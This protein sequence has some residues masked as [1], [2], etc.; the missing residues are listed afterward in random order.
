[1]NSKLRSLLL[2][3]SAIAMI[4]IISFLGVKTQALGNINDNIISPIISE[5][6]D[7]SKFAIQL[8]CVILALIVS[9]LS[10]ITNLLS[11]LFRFTGGLMYG[12]FINNP[13]DTELAYIRPLWSFL[14]DF[15]NLVVIGSFIA[16]ALVILFDLDLPVSKSLGN[17]AGGIVMVALLLN[18]SLT[19]TSAF[20]STI[21]SIGIGTVYATQSTAGTN[22]D[23]TSRSAFN[24]SV[25]KT[26]NKFFE[27]VN[28]N[29]VNKVSCMGSEA[30]DYKTDKDGRGGSLSMATV[31][32][33]HKLNQQTGPLT[34]WS[35]IA[36]SAEGTPEALIFYMIALIREVIVLILLVAGIYV[37][38]TLLKVSL[39]RLAYLWI[40]GIFAGPALVAAFSPFDGMKNYFKTWLKWL[41]VF[42][43]MMIVFVAGFYLSSY[44]ATISL[45]STGIVFEPLGNPFT[46]PG[47]FITGL[48]NSMVEVVVP[49]IM[50]PIIGLVILFLLGK[51]LDETYQTHAVKAMKAGGKLLSDARNSV[52][53][54]G[55]QVVGLGA[56]A[57][58]NYSN[59]GS[60]AANMYNTGLLK[61]NSALAASQRLRRNEAG[62]KATDMRATKYAGRAAVN[63][64]MI[65]NKNQSID[66]FISGKDYK[67]KRAEVEYLGKMNNSEVLGRLGV[68][69]S[70]FAAEAKKSGLSEDVIN[71]GKSMSKLAKT[72]NAGNGLNRTQQNKQIEKD[73]ARSE[74]KK[75]E[76]DFRDTQARLKTSAE[77]QISNA[78]EMQSQ[79]VKDTEAAYLKESN[80]L[81]DL[82]NKKL[83]DGTF[84][85]GNA[86]YNAKAFEDHKRKVLANENG[87]DRKIKESKEKLSNVKVDIQKMIEKIDEDIS[88]NEVVTT[89]VNQ[90]F[91][92]E[93]P[94]IKEKVADAIYRNDKVT[95]NTKSIAGK[96]Q[97]AVDLQQNIEATA[98][99]L[100]Q[101]LKDIDSDTDPNNT[102]ENKQKRKKQLLETIS[103]SEEHIKRAAERKY[104]AFKANPYLDE[105][106]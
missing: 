72:D 23:L 76:D 25:L 3:L 31:C 58:K 35:L 22:L 14:V 90:K 45:P 100:F 16:L 65:A 64:Q 42:S 87:R 8:V 32:Q 33:F 27:S 77:G 75:F 55:R 39:F 61:A 85:T 70:V 56:G 92:N 49:T 98:D 20:A 4:F 73:L 28:N 18:F 29:F 60:G 10:I 68:N 46:D 84:Q 80:A 52:A 106:K 78:E 38:I 34:P 97:Q 99:G 2:R 53:S 104:N 19:F 59:F 43:T 26:G 82:Y 12:F 50:F 63:K 7:L 54:G 24:R 44:I 6:L 86:N 95:N 74:N 30:V 94:N 48:V 17:F 9:I 57:A 62:A 102:Y 66:D 103:S 37:L 11:F 79:T 51:Y 91:L 89:A 41:V 101:Q 1:M 93:N 83:A 96:N 47:P 81:D 67:A 105:E 13:L 36:S 88:T 40:V 5:G 21:H 15:G 69:S 71:R